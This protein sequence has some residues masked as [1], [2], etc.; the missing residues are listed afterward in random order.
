MKSR[1]IT[2][3]LGKQLSVLYDPKGSFEKLAE[4]SLEEV[5]GSYVKALIIMGVIA[6]ILNILFALVQTSYLQLFHTIDVYYLNVINYSFARSVGILFVYIFVGTFFGFFLAAAMNIF[7]KKYRFT[8]FIKI[9]I[10][11][12]APM[13][14]LGWIPPSPLPFAI[15]AAI[16]LAA[17]MRHYQPRQVTRD[18]IQHRD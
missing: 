2:G 7:Q 3:I 10:C 5:V 1:G 13:V 18:S 17:G 11:S 8:E 16:L 15:W 14:L 9:V 4:R 6:G 12:S